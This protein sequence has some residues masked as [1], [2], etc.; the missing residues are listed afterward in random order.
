MKNSNW[1]YCIVASTMPASFIRH[2]YNNLNIQRIYVFSSEHKASFSYL[3]SSIPG[4]RIIVLPSQLLIRAAYIS[5]LLLSTHLLRRELIIFHE[6]CVPL[7]DVLIKFIKPCGYHFPLVTLNGYN[8][9][10]KSE[11]T[12]NK[13]Y[14]LLE[15]FGIL[16]MFDLYISPDVGSSGKE[17]ALKI[18]SYPSTMKLYNVTDSRRMA[19]KGLETSTNKKFEGFSILYILGQSFIDDSSQRI[20][21][22]KLI[23]IAQTKGFKCYIKDHPNP[24][25]R[26]NLTYT[27]VIY[28]PPELPI[29]ILED[30]YDLA[31]G[32]SSASL[33][34]FSKRSI[35]IIDL[36]ENMNNK[37]KTL[38][39]TFYNSSDM[40]DSGIEFISTTDQYEARLDKIVRDREDGLTSL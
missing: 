25:Y 31:V 21:F 33:I 36:F 14:W 35:C 12:R 11:I 34:W 2:Q 29:E 10:I 32:L 38:I 5:S 8:K 4:L 23:R 24:L 27:N 6:C 28:I 18:K 40:P 37:D 3:L 16:N 20:I 9:T 13:R 17:Y 19:A 1:S 39:R 7:L 26:L 22:T 30:P 15:F